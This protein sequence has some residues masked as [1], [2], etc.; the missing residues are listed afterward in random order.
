MHY[1]P[2]LLIITSFIG[3]NKI[4]PITNNRRRCPIARAVTAM[5]KISTPRIKS[6]M[7]L[8]E[9]L[10]I[11]N[12]TIPLYV[13][14]NGLITVDTV[15]HSAI[16]KLSLIYYWDRFK[17]VASHD[18]LWS[19]LCQFTGNS[20]VFLFTANGH[21]HNAPTSIDYLVRKERE[22]ALILSQACSK[23]GKLRSL[24]A[25]FKSFPI[26]PI[27][28][29]MIGVSVAVIIIIVAIAIAYYYY[30]NYY[31]RAT[32]LFSHQHNPNEE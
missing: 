31:Y 14:A 8:I 4:K 25:T 32:R 13:N 20:S 24:A 26:T 9:Y 11:I 19:A 5:H 23:N 10:P 15:Y 7:D 22:C 28:P 29:R 17:C 16:F 30:Y 18:Y 2:L 1:H 6:I 12:D 27:T 21:P 3:N